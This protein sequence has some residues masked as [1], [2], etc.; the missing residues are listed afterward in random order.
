MRTRRRAGF[1]LVELMAVMLIVALLFGVGAGLFGRIDVSDRVGRPL[2]QS[3]LR[4]AQNWAVSRGAPA[5][6]R[7]DRARG[8]LRAEGPVVVGTW[9]FEALPI[10]GA[11]GLDG[12]QSG[13]R[14]VEDGFQGQALSFVGEPA[15]SGVDIAIQGDPAFDLAE[16]F[17]VRCALR[18]EPEAAAVVLTIGEVVGLEVGENGALACWFVAE[19]RDEQQTPL[20]GGRISLHAG[21]HTLV[22]GRWEQVELRYDRNAFELFVDGAR[23]AQVAE[24]TRVWRI[25]GALKLSPGQTP[26]AGAID[27]LVVCAVGASEEAEL[28]RSTHFAPDAPSEILFQAGGGLDRAR[29]PEAVHLRLLRDEGP[30]SVVTVQPYG[31]V[32]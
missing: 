14:L 13:G 2:V 9:H 28:P 30:E 6:V 5:L 17:C 32:Q 4:S 1:T 22:P 16:G 25:E 7:I 18:V 26:F 29:H 24:Q 23:V 10:R 20:R 27:S 19:R 8:T 12:T 15:R 3:V 21:A 31:T 11:F